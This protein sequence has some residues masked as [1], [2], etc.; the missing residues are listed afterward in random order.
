MRFISYVFLVMV[1]AGSAHAQDAP[2]A[3]GPMAMKN[4]NVEIFIRQ[5]DADKND[6]MSK[7]EWKAAGLAEMPF[8]FCDSDKD[9]DL[10]EKEIRDCKLP[11]AMD[12]DSDGA[13]TIDEMIEFDKKMAS[14]LPRKYVPMD[15]YVEGGETGIDFIRLFDEAPH[16][17]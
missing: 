12:S 16:K 1:V 14:A 10:S 6:A 9:G 2:L 17:S 11:E 3:G 7:E 8:T 13:L 5:V 15:T 4:Y